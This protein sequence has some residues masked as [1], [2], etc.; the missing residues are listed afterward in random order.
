ML[1]LLIVD[2]EADVC[3]FAKSFFE[4]RDFHVVTTVDSKQAVRIFSRERPHIVLIDIKMKEMD[5]VMLL[6]KIRKIDTEAQVIMVS[7][8]D[9]SAVVEE[10]KKHGAT[11]YITKPL[12]LEDL[13]KVVLKKAAWIRDKKKI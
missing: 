8:V 4:A 2:D 10:A 3:K 5:G 12:V 9:D 11:E 1:K 7:A 13:E 6:K